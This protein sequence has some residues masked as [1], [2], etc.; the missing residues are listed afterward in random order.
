MQSEQHV[1]IR[2]KYHGPSGFKGSRITAT[3]EGKRIT[4]SWDYELGS[5]ENHE[6]AALVFLKKHLPDCKIRSYGAIPGGY[7]FL[8]R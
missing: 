7:V 6:A 4:T 3:Y 1:V 5:P 2:T 8:V